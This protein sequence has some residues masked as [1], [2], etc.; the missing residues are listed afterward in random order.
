MVEGEDVEEVEDV[1]L[2]GHAHLVGMINIYEEIRDKG[3]EI[4][5]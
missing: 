2:G 4:R 1:L 5:D 3:L